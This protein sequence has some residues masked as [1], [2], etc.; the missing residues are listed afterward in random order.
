[1]VRKKTILAGLI[2]LA[3]PFL[4][5]SQINGG[6]PGS[7]FG[8]VGAG[9]YSVDVFARTTH[10]YSNAT[11]HGGGIWSGEIDEIISV[12]SRTR[13]YSINLENRYPS[14][15][16]WDAADH[17]VARGS[18]P[19]LL[20]LTVIDPFGAARVFAYSDRAI[21]RNQKPSHRINGDNLPE[22][23]PDDADL[24]DCVKL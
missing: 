4:A 20:T 22:D 8:S 23:V 12:G 21:Y 10:D 9:D 18:D 19:N 14:D 7:V 1:M 24:G 5:H 3:V 15:D 2:L 17:F 11:Y 13:N 6:P 16:D